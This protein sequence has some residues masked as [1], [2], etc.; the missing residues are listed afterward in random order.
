MNVVIVGGTRGMGREVSRVMAERGDT[1]VLLGRRQDALDAARADL[2]AR[3]ASAVHTVSFD[4]SDANRHDDAL[5]EAEA[6]VGRLDAVVLTA[7]AFGTQEQLE[8]DAARTMAMFDLNVTKTIHFCELARQRLLVHGGGSLVAF[9]SVAGDKGRKT[10]G[11]YGASKA[12]LSHYL[13]SLDLRYHNQG[14]HVLSV[15]PGFIHTDMTAGLKPPPFA[16]QPDE[17]ARD[18]V[19]AIDRKTP[20]VYTPWIWQWVMLVI[21]HLPRFVMRRV[22]F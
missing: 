11:L 9:S 10:V 1:L 20:M 2:E 15:K 19:R 18:V 8:A 4:L 17:V 14:L 22:G 6:L 12:A 13:D 7:G 5:D 21:M 16:G 3:G